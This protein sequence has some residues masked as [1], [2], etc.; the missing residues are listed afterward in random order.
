MQSS[1]FSQLRKS[2]PPRC[3]TRIARDRCSLPP[4]PTSSRST[5]FQ[6]SKTPPPKPDNKGKVMITVVNMIPND[7]SD[8]QNQDTEANLSVNPA[9]PNEIIATTFTFD[10]PAGTSAVSPAMTGNWAP[11]FYSND[12]GNSWTLQYVLPSGP[13]AIFPTF[14]VTVRYGGNSGVVYSGLISAVSGAIQICRA[15][16]VFTHQAQL[17]TDSG[18]QPYV[19][20]FTA[21]GQDKVYVGYNNGATIN[22]SQDA[23]TAPAPAG[24]APLLIDSRSGSDGPKIRTAIHGN[25][26]VYGAFYSSNAGAWDVVVVKDLN[27]GTSAPPYQAL[28][29]SGDALAGVRVVSGISLATSNL[30]YASVGP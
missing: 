15:P 8:E 5:G 25:G 22:Q 28:I 27:W 26:V 9:I 3:R 24:F 19:E 10:N 1:F 21:F 29:D 11:V 20:T 17:A 2:G 18:D 12:G 4:R 7:W 30:K 14:D 6:P 16:D 23:A 13:G